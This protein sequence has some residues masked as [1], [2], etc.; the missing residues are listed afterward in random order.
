MEL[1]KSKKEQRKKKIPFAKTCVDGMKNVEMK[2]RV[3]L[4]HPGSV[5]CTH[6]TVIL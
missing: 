1:G 5:Q 4:T 3:T 2:C 6:T